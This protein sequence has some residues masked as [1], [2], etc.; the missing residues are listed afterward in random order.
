MASGANNTFRQV[1]IATGIAGLGTVFQSQIQ[2][3]TLAA[4]N[5]SEAGKAIV[6][7]GGAQLQGALVGGGVREAMGSIPSPALRS[8]LL[9]AYQTGFAATLD[10]LMIIA[11]VIAFIGSVAS[12]V[13]VRQRDFVPSVAHGAPP[14]PATPQSAPLAPVPAPG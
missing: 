2:N 9:D 14:A 1:G 10:H 13:L 5:S 6:S 3:H 7:H 11:T 8:V 4:L 12:F